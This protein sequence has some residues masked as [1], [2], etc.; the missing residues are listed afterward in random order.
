MEKTA[1]STLFNDLFSRTTWVSQKKQNHSG[2]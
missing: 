1:T 2:F